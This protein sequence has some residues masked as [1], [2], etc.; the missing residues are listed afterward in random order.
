MVSVKSANYSENISDL[1]TGLKG[2]LKHCA[3]YLHR[4]EFHQYIWSLP[5]LNIRQTG[6][7]NIG[8]ASIIFTS[9]NSC[10]RP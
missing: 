6:L 10:R 9:Q 4:G 8:E 2:K 7:E 1:K 3:D 5:N